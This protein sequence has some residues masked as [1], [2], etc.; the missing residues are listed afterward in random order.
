MEVGV[1]AASGQFKRL[2]DFVLAARGRGSGTD[3]SLAEEHE[4]CSSGLWPVASC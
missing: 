1:G 2:N 3:G 4:V